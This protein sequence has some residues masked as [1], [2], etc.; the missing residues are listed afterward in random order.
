[1]LASI[2]ALL[3]PAA[4]AVPVGPGRSAQGQRGNGGL[5][6]QPPVAPAPAAISVSR[7]R[8]ARGGGRAL[9]DPAFGGVA[10]PAART[11]LEPESP[12]GPDLDRRGNLAAAH[13]PAA[14]LIP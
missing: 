9:P 2:S 1:G 11:G 4:A 13:P 5:P 8:R 7:G 3:G 6:G 14:R 10:P 12:A